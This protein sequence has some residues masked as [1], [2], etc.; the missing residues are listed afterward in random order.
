MPGLDEPP[1]DT[2]FNP[3]PAFGNGFPNMLGLKKPERRGIH[4]NPTMNCRAKHIL[5]ETIRMFSPA[6][7][8]RD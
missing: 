4:M 6:F 7:Q 5:Y 8:C 1:L 3:L 2:G